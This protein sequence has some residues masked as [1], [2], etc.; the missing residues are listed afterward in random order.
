MLSGDRP[1]AVAAAAQ[2]PDRRRARPRA[3]ASCSRSTPRRRPRRPRDGTA[4]SA[5][6]WR[7]E[8]RTGR[9]PG[10]GVSS[11]SLRPEP[12]GQQRHLRSS[13][14]PGP[15]YLNDP[16]KPL[17]NRPL[18]ELYPPGSTFKLVTAAAA[19][20]SGQVHHRRPLIPVAGAPHPARHDRRPAQRQRPRPAATAHVTLSDALE[21]SCNTVF[22]N[23]GHRARRRRRC[24]S[25]PQKFGFNHSF[26]V[27]D[28]RG[29]QPSSP[30][31]SSRPRRR[32]PR[33]ASSTSGA[34]AL[35]MAM[36][37]AAIANNGVV[38]ERRTS[39]QRCSGRDLAAARPPAVPHPFGQAMS[40]PRSR[41]SSPT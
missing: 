14:R 11:P 38:I 25:R 16:A 4:R 6:S 21:V 1:A 22:A 29:H 39:S 41:R 20:S 5:R 10:P 19:L 15:S 30:T 2:R 33:S 17:L 24:S 13:R 34:T 23:V 35:Q 27:P 40:P 37:A 3:A 7:I 9:D 31:D 36:V 26:E 12:V 8:P 32:S 28:D 18:A